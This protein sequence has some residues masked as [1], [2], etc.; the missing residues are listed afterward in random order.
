KPQN[1]V[2][3]NKEKNNMLTIKHLDAW[4]CDQPII[5]KI[6]DVDDKA[7]LRVYHYFRGYFSKQIILERNKIIQEY[8]SVTEAWDSIHNG[9][10]FCKFMRELHDLKMKLLET[11]ELKYKKENVEYIN[12]DSEICV[13]INNLSH[14]NEQNNILILTNLITDLWDERFICYEILL[15]ELNKK[16]YFF[17]HKSSDTIICFRRDKYD[18][19]FDMLNELQ[20]DKELYY[21]REGLSGYWDNVDKHY[22]TFKDEIIDKLISYNGTELIPVYFK[23][24]NIF[25]SCFPPILRHDYTLQ[26]VGD[27]VEEKLFQK[28]LALYN[29]GNWNAKYALRRSG[30]KL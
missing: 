12:I 25:H 21:D 14:F 2:Y 29:S 5:G 10:D 13:E 3:N 30:Y 1:V 19:C 6:N 20:I 18:S 16:M 4:L 7:I 22:L 9:Y 28:Y 23:Y 27:F 15:R 24:K 26:P 11:S 8:G 17:I